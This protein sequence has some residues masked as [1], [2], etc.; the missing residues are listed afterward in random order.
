MSYWVICGDCKDIIL[1]AEGN[2]CNVGV[3]KKTH[4]DGGWAY[5]CTGCGERLQIP[6]KDNKYQSGLRHPCRNNGRI[7]DY[8]DAKAQ[9][10]R[11][12]DAAVTKVNEKSSKSKQNKKKKPANPK[13]KKST[14]NTKVK[15]N[16]KTKEAA[17][18]AHV[19]TTTKKKSKSQPHPEKATKWVKLFVDNPRTCMVTHKHID[20]PYDK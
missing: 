1:F 14:L 6:G 8:K 4:S 12:L 13:S 3:C 5:I 11:L 7:K 2:Y 18:P 17:K 20:Y 16:Y 19:K 15:T 10:Q 9:Q